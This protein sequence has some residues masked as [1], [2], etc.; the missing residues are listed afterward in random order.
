[1]LRRIFRPNLANTGADMAA[2]R[3]R[4]SFRRGANC[5]PLLAL[6]L[7]AGC[8]GSDFGSTLSAGWDRIRSPFMG[9]ANVVTGDSLTIQ[10]VRGSNPTVQPLVP[11][12]GDVWP[13]EEAARPTMMGGPDEA[14]RNIPSYRPS[15]IDGAPPAASPVPTPGTRRGSSNPPGSLGAPG[16][17]PRSPAAAAPPGALTPPAARLEGRSLTTPSGGL[18][19]GTGGTPRVQ[20]Y[21]GPQGGGAVIRD[22]NVETW[23]GPDGRTSTRVVPN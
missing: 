14:M 12:T 17:Y 13:G 18:V 22:G 21:T 2:E 16:E 11:E 6:T 20:G 7:L 15:L 1:M 9:S 23:I 4:P 10:R 3:Y 19:T 8:A 5:A